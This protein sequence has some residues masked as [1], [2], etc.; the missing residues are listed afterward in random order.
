[1][2]VEGNNDSSHELQYKIAI[3]MFKVIAFEMNCYM[4]NF[5]QVC[6]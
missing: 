3:Y 2:S 4:F 6:L 5:F 1:M